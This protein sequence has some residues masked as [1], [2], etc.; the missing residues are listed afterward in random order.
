[1]LN[2]VSRAVARLRDVAMLRLYTT[3]M[4]DSQLTGQGTS[5]RSRAKTK[6]RMLG[7][8]G[9]CAPDFLII[10]SQSGFLS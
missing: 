3:V 2:F 7:I 8:P 9:G 5:T 4:E 6:P 10:I 1:M